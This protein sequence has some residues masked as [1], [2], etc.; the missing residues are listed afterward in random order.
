MDVFP[1]YQQFNVQTFKKEDDILDIIGVMIEKEHPD[2]AFFIVDLTKV[3]D[4]YNRWVEKLPRIKPY[5]AIKCNPND[6]IIRTLN[7][8][9]AGFDCAS[10]N[11]IAKV[12]ELGA[13]PDKVIYANPTKSDD[14]IAFAR[15]KDIDLLTFDNEDELYK[16]RLLHPDAKL[17]LRIKVDD[18]KS[19]CRFSCKFG[20]GLDEIERILQIAKFAKL[21]I[22]GVSF[23]V[24]SNCRSTEL[25]DSAIKDA[26]KV[27]DEAKK[28]GFDA[29]ILDIGGGFTGTDDAEIKFED[30]ADQI[31]KSID[32][33]FNEKEFPDLEI[34]A[35]P[36]RYFACS[37][38]TLVLRVIGKKKI[39]DKDTGDTIICYT[40]NDGVYGS[41]NCI[42]YDHQNPK[43]CPYNERDNVT[44][45]SVVY[46]PTCDSV[47]TISKDCYLPDLAISERVYVENFGAYTGAAA[48]TFNGFQQTPCIYIVKC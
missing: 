15:A 20:L 44:F 25:Y 39:T 24:G 22:V 27:F 36:G 10:K 8:L 12:L 48:S 9:G 7:M 45:K 18:S 1:I 13:S 26:R 38:H 11:E 34:I 29:K 40:L 35:E 17:I 5:Y 41:F 37:S 33:Y 19:E 32:V 43:I 46:G 4:Q 31:T 28:M 16:L 14:N 42:Q 2:D 6:M 47:D 30:V 3:I 21:N 23:H